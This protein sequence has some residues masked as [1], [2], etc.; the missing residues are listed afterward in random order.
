[1]N[2]ERENAD[3][4]HGYFESPNYS[5][6]DLIDNDFK[7]N[8]QSSPIKDAVTEKL[9]TGPDT[10]KIIENFMPLHHLNIVLEK[11]HNQ[12]N[13]KTFTRSYDRANWLIQ[14]YKTRMKMTAEKLFNLEL[15]YDDYASPLGED[16]HVAGRKP[17]F[18][19]EVHSD[20]LDI[21]KNKYEKYMWSGHISNLLYLND[22]YEGGELYFPEHDLMIKPKPGMLVS[23]PGNFWNRH[24][25]LPA[26]EY[27]FAISIF[28]KIKNFE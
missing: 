21:D 7:H 13:L 23:F 20:N 1:M 22:N 5:K 12:Y 6:Q 4:D 16:F 25:I 28:F 19:T 10:I 27:R 8:A 9:G 15:D 14:N 24:G 3:K 26:S 17:H 18:V 2:N 11:V